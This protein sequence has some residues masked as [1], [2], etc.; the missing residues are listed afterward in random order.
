MKTIYLSSMTT[1]FVRTLFEMRVFMLTVQ[2]APTMEFFSDVFSVIVAWS[3]TAVSVICVDRTLAC[4]DISGGAFVG[5]ICSHKP[6][7]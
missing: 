6:K 7:I 5:N 4:A 2:F 1:P 3:L